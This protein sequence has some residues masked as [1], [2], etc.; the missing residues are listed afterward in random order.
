MRELLVIAGEFIEHDRINAACFLL[1]R[2]HKRCDGEPW[3]RDFVEG[4]ATEVIF[5]GYFAFFKIF[6]KRNI[7]RLISAC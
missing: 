3:L 5:Y 4:P 2:A 1:Q 7:Y 6:L